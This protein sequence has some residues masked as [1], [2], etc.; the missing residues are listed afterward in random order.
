MGNL[1]RINKRIFFAIFLVTDTK[2]M[3][4]QASLSAN[5]TVLK[6]FLRFILSCLLVIRHF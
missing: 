2:S 6:I 4:A 3:L 5:F 1:E